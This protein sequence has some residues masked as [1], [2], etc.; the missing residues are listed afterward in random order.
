[1]SPKERQNLEEERVNLK[2]ILDFY[3]EFRDHIASMR[4]KE[5]DRHIDDILDRIIEINKQL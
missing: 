2:K 1:M 4:D 5:I 3:V